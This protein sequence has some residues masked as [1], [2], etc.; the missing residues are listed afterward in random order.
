MTDIIPDK[1]ALA[2]TPWRVGESVGGKFFMYD[3]NGKVIIVPNMSSTRRSP[4]ELRQ[5]YTT[6]VFAV[7]KLVEQQDEEFR[8]WDHF[9]KKGK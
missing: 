8:A 6:I 9:D 2:P 3:A 7:N 1:H 4:Q 5:I